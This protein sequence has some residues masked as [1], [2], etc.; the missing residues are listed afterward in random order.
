MRFSQRVVSPRPRSGWHTYQ[1]HLTSRQRSQTVTP[2]T[3]AVYDLTC[4]CSTGYGSR[5]RH[6]FHRR[7]DTPH[8][9]TQSNEAYH[10]G[11]VQTVG[12]SANHT[13]RRPC[14]RV[15]VVVAPSAIR[16]GHAHLHGTHRLTAHTTPLLGRSTG[17]V[18]I[19]D[20]EARIASLPPRRPSLLPPHLLVRGSLLPHLP[21]AKLWQCAHRTDAALCPSVFRARELPQR[22]GVVVPAEA[23]LVRGELAA[24]RFVAHRRHRHSLL[25]CRLDPRCTQPPRGAPSD[26]RLR[27]THNIRSGTDARRRWR[28]PAL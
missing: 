28:G 16:T 1:G 13:Q 19:F 23:V 9:T 12:E 6:S 21:K 24:E 2:L 4:T 5:V 11:M 3:A 22:S 27:V 17:V 18:R 25:L 7:K 14:V 15:R 10:T 26:A 8:T 20:P